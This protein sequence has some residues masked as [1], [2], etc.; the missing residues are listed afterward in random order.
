VADGERVQNLLS[1]VLEDSSGNPP[2]HRFAGVSLSQH[3]GAVATGMGVYELEPGNA[4]WPYHFEAVE[5]EWLIVIEGELTLR[6]PA[7]EAV[8]RAGDVA[9]F[10][11]GAAGAHAVR[12]HTDA[13]VRYAMPST[14]APYGDACVYPDSGKVRVAAPGFDHRG[15][16]GEPADYWEGEQ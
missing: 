13:P 5:E 6:T 15:W 14:N 7:G 16:L 10:P 12:N 3:F 8:L 4:A 9:S 11:A 1:L 2:G